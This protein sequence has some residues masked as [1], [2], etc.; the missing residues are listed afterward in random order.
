M[1]P[2]VIVCLMA[3]SLGGC[4]LDEAATDTANHRTIATANH[5]TI[6]TA[7]HRTIDTTRSTTHDRTADATTVANCT[8][9]EIHSN[10]C[11]PPYWFLEAAEQEC[12]AS[13]HVVDFSAGLGHP[14]SPCANLGNDHAKFT[15]CPKG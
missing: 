10:A 11:H 12:G 13:H 15:C 8:E 7:N 3:V 2:F 5:R 4:G 1:V 6:D 14:Q 9:H